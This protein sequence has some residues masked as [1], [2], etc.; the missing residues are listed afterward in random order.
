MTLEEN[1]IENIRNL[2]RVHKH[3]G[4]MCSKDKV[5]FAFKSPQTLGK[6][7]KRVSNVL[8][9]SPRKRTAVITSLVTHLGLELNN[10]KQMKLDA[11]S[12]SAVCEEKINNISNV[13]VSNLWMCPG[14]KDKFIIRKPGKEKKTVQKQ[15]M[16]TT[17]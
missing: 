4:K 11:V 5:K 12:S 14:Q 3:S 9:K 17:L 6:A 2:E 8:P 1:E 15:Y 10:S 13:Y 16:L 7:K